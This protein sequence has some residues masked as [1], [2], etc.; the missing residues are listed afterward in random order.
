MDGL[1]RARP[2]SRNP[3]VGM[4]PSKKFCLGI[5]CPQNAL[6][7]VADTDGMH[8]FTPSKDR[9]PFQSKLIVFY[10]VP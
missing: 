2:K 8:S 5:Y 9:T 6:V 7:H 3:R 10:L 1:E 4:D